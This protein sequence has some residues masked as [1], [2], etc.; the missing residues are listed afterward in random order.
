MNEWIGNWLEEILGLQWSIA[1]FKRKLILVSIVDSMDLEKSLLLILVTFDMSC[2]PF[3]CI[4][5]PDWH[6]CLSI[7][8]SVSQTDLSSV[9]VSATLSVC[10]SRISRGARSELARILLNMERFFAAQPSIHRSESRQQQKKLEDALTRI[11]SLRNWI[12]TRTLAKLYS[13]PTIVFSHVIISV[14][15]IIMIGIV[16]VYYW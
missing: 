13:W 1:F 11:L 16:I 7:C 6:V 12:H 14:V 2:L 4:C 5:M 9:S 8:L 3:I 15:L 10:M